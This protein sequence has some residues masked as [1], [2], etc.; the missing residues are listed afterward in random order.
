MVT[1]MVREGDPCNES[2]VAHVASVLEMSVLS[3]LS[4]SLLFLLDWDKD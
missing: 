1:L 2:G 4:L 3:F